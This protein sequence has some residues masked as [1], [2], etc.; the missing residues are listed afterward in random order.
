MNAD[1]ESLSLVSPESANYD[2][3]CFAYCDNNAINRADSSGEI[4]HIVAG[5]VV[6]GVVSA[7]ASAIT[8]YVTEGKIDLKQT[9][10]AAGSGALS[11]GLAASG[12]GLGAMALGNAAISAGESIL[13]QG[14]EKG[15]NNIKIGEVA[16]DAGVGA[17][18][19]LMGG[20]GTGNKN[21][22]NLGKQSVRRT[23]N[24]LKYGGITRAKSEARKAARYYI[25]STG[26]YYVKN[27]GVKQLAREFMG[28]IGSGFASNYFARKWGLS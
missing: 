19:G 23:T 25:K 7:A 8:Q 2:K 3:N 24:A 18:S 1:D 28:N 6:G 26:S 27:Y 4:W 20:K 14:V 15:F 22:T 17:V 16:L 21:L 12:L 10:I 13:S 11:G 5:A 9:F